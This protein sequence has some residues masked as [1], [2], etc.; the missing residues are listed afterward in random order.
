MDR[1]MLS[2]VSLLGETLVAAKLLTDEWPLTRMH[3]QVIKEVMPLAEKHSAILV[4]AFQNL[5]LAHRARIFVF[6]NAKSAGRRDCLL[7]FNRTEVKVT[8]VLDMNL[9]V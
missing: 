7:D 5:D 9:S 1:Q 4:V 6:K 2:Q 3:S 8:A